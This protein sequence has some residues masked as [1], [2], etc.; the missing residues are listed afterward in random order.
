MLTLQSSLDLESW[1]QVTDPWR[2]KSIAKSPA[3]LLRP[4]LPFGE[5]WVKH[6]AFEGKSW[7]SLRTQD[8]HRT[9]Q[10]TALVSQRES[11]NHVWGLVLLSLSLSPEEIKWGK[12]NSRDQTSKG[13]WF[14]RDMWD[15]YHSS[16]WL[17]PIW[18]SLVAFR[19]FSVQK[20]FSKEE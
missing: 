6:D 19:P 17:R 5:V 15:D 4:Q 10:N 12:S 20:S 3:S 13:S 1:R 14:T 18:A 16:L 8:R 9:I 7:Y 11:Q 2:D